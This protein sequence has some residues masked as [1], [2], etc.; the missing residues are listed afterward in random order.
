M[1]GTQATCPTISYHEGAFNAPRDLGVTL[2]PDNP[3]HVPNHALI[4]CAYLCANTRNSF[5]NSCQR[6]EPVITS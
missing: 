4:L 5:G 2:V 3:A 6:V 1:A